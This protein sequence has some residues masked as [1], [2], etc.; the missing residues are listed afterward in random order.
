MTATT[1]TPEAVL[2]GFPFKKGVNLSLWLS[3][4]AAI[5]STIFGM[6]FNLY[7]AET[8]VLSFDK[9]TGSPRSKEAI[10]RETISVIVLI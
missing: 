7:L 2:T 6:P 10:R 3:G 8:L 4:R 9:L 5:I 1:A